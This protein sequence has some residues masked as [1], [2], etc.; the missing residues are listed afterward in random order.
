MIFRKKDKIEHHARKFDKFI[1]GLI[2][3]GAVASIFWFSRTKKGQE[4]TQ[5]ITEEGK[6]MAQKGYSVFGKVLVRTLRLFGKK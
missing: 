5:K 2:I 4:V 6:T 3:G 1:T